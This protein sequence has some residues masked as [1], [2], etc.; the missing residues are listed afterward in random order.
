MRHSTTV[1]SDRGSARTIHP[2]ARTSRT[3]RPPARLTLAI[4]VCVLA[5]PPTARW[6]QQD[7]LFANDAVAND[8]FGTSVAI[9]GDTI[10]VGAMFD[11]TLGG[12]QAGSAYVF[13]RS[14]VTWSEQAQLLAGDG[15]PEDWFGESVGISDDTIVVG[16]RKDDTPAGTDAGSAYVFVRSGTTWNPDGHIYADDADA[17]D[18]FGISVGI[19]GT[20]IVVGA[21]SDNT[22]GGTDA[23]SAYVFT[24]G[25]LNWSQ[26]DHLFATVP[27][28]G[29][30][31][32]NRVAIDGD[33]IVVGAKYWDSASDDFVGSA[34]VFTRTAGTW[35]QQGH[36]TA[37]D[38]AASDE[39]ANAVAISGD[40]IVIG[41]RFDDTDAGIDAGSAYVFARS[42]GTWSQQDHLFADD[43][44]AGDF[45]GV[46]VAISGDTIV[47]G[48]R[49]DDT[50]AAIHSGSAY[51]FTRV[52]ATWSQ[53][54]RLFASDA[55]IGDEFGEAVA[56]AGDTAVVGVADSDTVAG[57][58][59]GSAYVYVL[60]FFD[61]FVGEPPAMVPVPR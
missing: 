57:L 2:T 4:A 47:V 32:G 48:S 43:A 41:S 60:S 24:R 11:K 22:P 10:V 27:A 15:E 45:F 39:F 44:I 34:Y 51:V 7:H 13:T 23:G 29:D 12:A 50:V 25:A 28:A 38:G 36:L 42:G 30:I 9:S 26:Q 59:A 17:V 6:N 5:L 61:V 18:R 14:G 35:T 21:S 3:I 1:L 52:G 20:T 40:L 46:A 16:A 53:Q 37:D 55:G 8:L 19:S 31:F 33:T 49:L 56:L 54:G 58:N